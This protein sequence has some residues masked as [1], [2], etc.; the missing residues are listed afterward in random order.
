MLFSSGFTSQWTMN[1]LTVR[2][3][4]PLQISGG[5]I[6]RLMDNQ[7]ESAMLA[8]PGDFLIAIA[9]LTVALFTEPAEA[10]QYSFRVY[11]LDQGLN[12]L[13]VKG[14]YQDKKGF[15]WVST[16]NGIFR[17]D[18]ERFQS[19]GAKDGIPPSSGVAFGEAPDGSLLAGGEIGLF[20]KT[21][22]RFEPISMPGAKHVSWFSG[23]RSDGKGST[24]LATDAG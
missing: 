4:G 9:I 12:S 23:V 10:Q 22:D 17:Y 13:A 21:G 14:L 2:R 11:G 3:W 15:L 16:E 24:W 19:F 8:R 5:S 18:G 1:T 7:R 6:F 20:R